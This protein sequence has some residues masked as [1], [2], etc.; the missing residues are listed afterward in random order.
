[1]SQAK[2]TGSSLPWS[3]SNFF[4]TLLRFK[5]EFGFTVVSH[6]G[7]FSLLHNCMRISPHISS[8]D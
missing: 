4:F 3:V 5:S 6:A 2:L 7:I 8:K 1:M